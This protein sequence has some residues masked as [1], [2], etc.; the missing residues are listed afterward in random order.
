MSE[1]NNNFDRLVDAILDWDA[2]Q[3]ANFVILHSLKVWASDI[4]IE[5]WE[6][7]VRIRIRIDWVLHSLTEYQ[8][9]LHDAFIARIKIMSKLQTDE[10]RIPQDWVI[11]T[12]L[13][14]W[15][16]VD[17][18][19]STLP[20]VTWEKVCMRIQDKTKTIPTF[21][22]M[23]I[24]ASWLHNLET[25]I[26]KPNWI[27]LVTW[28]TWSWKTTTLYS[29]LS[30]LNQDGVNIMTVEDPV[31][32]KMAWL[33]QCQVVEKIWYTFP[34][35]LRAALRQDP[36]IIMLWEIRDKETV[37]IALRAAM[38]WHLVLSTIHTNSAVSTIN[39][40]LD[41]WVKP[42]LIAW[43]VNAIQAQRL[44]RRIC[45]NCIE[46]YTPDEHIIEDIKKELEWLPDSEWLDVSK[47]DS[48]VL[49]RWAW[50]E[51]CN[52]TW[53]KWRMW[54]YEVLEV[55]REIE[56]MVVAWRWELSILKRAKEKWF[57]TMIQDWIIKAIAW[58]TTIEEIFNIVNT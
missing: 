29:A 9:S 45:T 54:I 3:M 58:F 30:V 11:N 31:E 33:N 25:A 8:P 1:N 55:D 41:M 34:I 10:K 43:T 21:K 15:W 12:S 57:V 6:W 49:S 26:K 7:N 18:R 24:R 14:G 13:E 37:E 40:L 20:T 46:K 53:F 48:I 36:N 52:D 16:E 32:I 47:L 23:W 39:R 4:H 35:A 22:E 2:T 17:L 27:V 51:E 38:T 42:F 44:V 5:P 50:C 56:E 19:V 28:P